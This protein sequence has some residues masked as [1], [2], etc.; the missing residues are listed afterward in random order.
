MMLTFQNKDMA[1]DTLCPKALKQT[2][3]TILKNI[4][5]G[6]IYAHLKSQVNKEDL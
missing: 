3:W 1:I 6:K 4:R 5:I 2:K